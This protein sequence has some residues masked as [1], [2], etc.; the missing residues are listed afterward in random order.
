[1][2][3]RQDLK[4]ILPYLPLLV[5]ES[6]LFWPSKVVEALKSMA[7]GPEHSR[8]NSGEMLSVAICDIRSSVSL[9]EPLAPFALNG[10]ALF[11]DDLVSRAESTKW[12]EEVLPALANFLLQLPSL[13]ESHYQNAD[14]FLKRCGNKTGLRILGRQEAGIVFL[15]QELIGA[16]L[17]CSF[18]C[19]FPV[20]NRGSNHLPT[21]NFDELFASLYESYSE[22]QENKIKCI[23]H[24][25]ERISSS[26]PVGSVSFER[27]VL[28]LD[29]HPLFISYPDA[30]A[31]SKS[32]IPLCPFEAHSLG[33]M[34]DHSTDSLQVDFANKYIGGGALRRGC[35]QEEIHFMINPELIAGMLF[36]PSM[37]DNEAI[38]IVGAE[39]F[40]D[41]NGYASSFRFSGDHVDKRNVDVFGRRKIRIIA[42]DALCWPGM[43]QYELKY[44]LRE[45][46]KAL[47]GFID[48]S[49]FGQYEKLFPDGG[50]YEAN[51]E[52]NMPR[53]KF[54]EG[55]STAIETNEDKS[56]NPML[57]NSD[58]KSSQ[59]RNHKGFPGIVTGNWG[60]GAFG[61]DP[62]LKAII[63]WLAASQA[64]RPLMSYYTFGVEALENV[65]QVTQWIL[66]HEWTVGDLWNMMVEYSSQR[67]KGETSVGFF[68]WLLP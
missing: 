20:T 14:D 10:Y 38:D 5:R 50:L 67:L 9:L 33:L 39:R 27:K 40:S 41:Y 64:L 7:K 1:M 17:A 26:M 37:A 52:D 25:F 43:K 19:L 62:E 66:S 63:Q 54:L 45:T 49:N 51:D 56:V 15:S 3:K 16:L 11:F 21:I 31:W 28:P 18:F 6:T 59:F 42:I 55:S 34:E 46:N 35:V 60:C 68:T 44:L 12:F 22:N 53:N 4:S 61:G 65:G 32:V 57:R 13:L 36:L 2:D 23:V 29:H 47:C 30:D 24:Y 48:Q 58:P 8:V